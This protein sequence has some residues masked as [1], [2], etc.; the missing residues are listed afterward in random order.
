MKFHVSIK[1]TFYSLI[2]LKYCS[3]CE[4][5]H[6]VDVPHWNTNFVLSA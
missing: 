6:K 3:M 4:L 1:W 5:S 2:L